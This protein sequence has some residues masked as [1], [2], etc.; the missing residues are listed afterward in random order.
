VST[1]EKLDLV[2]AF[3]TLLVLAFTAGIAFARIFNV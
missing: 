3:L 2:L 1:T